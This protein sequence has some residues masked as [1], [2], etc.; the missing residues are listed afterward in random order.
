M[1]DPAWNIIQLNTA[2][3]DKVV[4][5]RMSKSVS[6]N[7]P[8]VVT[9]D[10]T[11]LL[12]IL[13]NLMSNSVKF[14]KAGGSIQLLVDI[15]PEAPEYSG[16]TDGPAPTSPQKHSLGRAMSR[17][18]SRPDRNDGNRVRRHDMASSRE[19]TPVDESAPA[20]PLTHR[21][22]VRSH[23][24]RS[25]EPSKRGLRLSSRLAGLEQG[26]GCSDTGKDREEVFLR[27]RVVDDGV[28]IAPG[29]P[30]ARIFLR[31]TVE[32]RVYHN[33]SSR[34]CLYLGGR[35]QGDCD[36]CLPTSLT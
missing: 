30:C 35:R 3:R 23:P 26:S 27:F 16:G 6:E 8:E 28:G 4:T 24:F 33:A 11:R 5:L 14:S 19:N 13:T 7:V 10:P 2:Q 32:R 36:N 22:S 17:L 18:F 29:E 25:Q 34:G 15:S 31:K 20:A 9:T 12:Q 1:I 21:P